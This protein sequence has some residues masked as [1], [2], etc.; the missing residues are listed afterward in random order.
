MLAA[1]DAGIQKIVKYLSGPEIAIS[2]GHN[3]HNCHFYHPRSM[4]SQKQR[5]QR[6]R[7]IIRGC[8]KPWIRLWGN[9]KFSELTPK[10]CS[11]SLLGSLKTNTRRSLISMIEQ[12]WIIALKVTGNFEDGKPSTFKPTSLTWQTFFVPPRLLSY[13]V[14][15]VMTP[16]KLDLITCWLG[17]AHKSEPIVLLWCLAVSEWIRMN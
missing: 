16:T 12:R 15:D 9:H 5:C 2:A 13:P 14:F 8:T 4:N 17:W 11:Y 3:I 6:Q 10:L 1:W 7:V